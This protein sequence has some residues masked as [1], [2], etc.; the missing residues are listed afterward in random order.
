MGRDVIDKVDFRLLA[1]LQANNLQTAEAL[2]EQ[3]GRSPSV[4]ARRLRRL[5]A[6]GAIAAEVAI[7][8][9]KVAGEPLFA[10]V[11]LVLERHSAIADVGRLKRE[12][13]A[14]PNVQLCLELAG[15]I[16]LLL[17]VVAADMDAYN[18]FT[19][20]MLEKPPVHRF[21]TTVVKNRAKASLALPL[22]Q[23]LGRR[24]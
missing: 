18:G 4:V 2:A 8:S 9:S 24:L 15:P 11:H 16:D 20:A 13:S 23:L 14:S 17:L 5:R 1:C 6:S 21:E 12:L 19:A 3:V 22:D 7:L 10:V